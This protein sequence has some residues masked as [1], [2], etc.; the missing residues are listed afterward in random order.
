MSDFDKPDG[1]PVVAESVTVPEAPETIRQQPAPAVAGRR[2]SPLLII[3]LILNLI[4]LAAVVWLYQGRQADTQALAELQ[5][6]QAGVGGHLQSLGQQLSQMGDKTR[7]VVHSNDALAAQLQ[8]I[9]KQLTFNTDAIARLPGVGQQDW[10]LAE[11]E[12]L[13]RL[14]SQRLQLER[15]TS[16]AI[17]MLGAADQVLLE[18]DNPVWNP[19]REKI[20]AELL[21]LRKVPAVDRSGAVLRL[22]AL[23]DAV[24]DLGWQAR[25]HFT[26]METGVAAEEVPVE[27]YQHLWRAVRDGVGQLVRIRRH[28]VPIDVPLT[29]DQAWYLQQGMRLMLEQSQAA[30]LRRDQALYDHSLKRVSDWLDLYV[31]TETDS[32]RAV[33]TGLAEVAAWK[34]APAVPDITGS[35]QVLRQLQERQR[36]GLNE[37]VSQ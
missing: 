24:D 35:L 18:T 26:L 10:L 37:D 22:Q 15:D 17:A 13:L 7:D 3:V 32:S 16:G 23:Q 6:S 31:T 8:T 9:Q 4:L 20:A 34:V 14:A 12:Y 30:L 36:R 11:A 5:A 19:V 1:G 29:Q 2:T 33:R 27:W 21:T 25:P 28:D